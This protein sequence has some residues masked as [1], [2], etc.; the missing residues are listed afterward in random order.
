MTL[1]NIFTERN[2]FRVAKWDNWFNVE[3]SYLVTA[4]DC[5]CPSRIK[6]CKHVAMVGVAKALKT[7]DTQMFLDPET[8]QWVG[9][10]PKDQFTEQPPK[11]PAWRRV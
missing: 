4:T 9:F 3:A 6:P 7:I 5:N 10:I 8:C 1:Y 11:R 2:G